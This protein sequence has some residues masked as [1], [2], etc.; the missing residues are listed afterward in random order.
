MN[1][2][3]ETSYMMDEIRTIE[4]LLDRYKDPDDGSER[5][6][7]DEARALAMLLVEN[8]CFINTR[9]YVEI[10]WPG[11]KETDRP[12]IRDDT[13]V[14]FMNCNDVFAWACADAESISTAGDE[15][16]D[17][18][19]Y[20]LTRLHLEHRTWGSTKWICLKRNEKP[21]RPMA[22]AMRK[23]GYWDEEMEALPDNNYDRLMRELMEEE[24]KRK[25]SEEKDE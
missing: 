22:D 3:G 12:K 7:F 5:V 10:T 14:V 15:V 24:R 23:A 25:E 2:G 6:F 4:D 21:Q 16:E 8:V 1:N 18:E 17:N 9:A 11:D 13:I 19:L 20:D